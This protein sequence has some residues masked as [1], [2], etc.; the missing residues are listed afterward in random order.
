MLRLSCREGFTNIY[1]FVLRDRSDI[2]TLKMKYAY[3]QRGVINIWLSC[4]AL[5]DPGVLKWPYLGDHR[6]LKWSFFGFY[7]FGYE[8]DQNIKKILQKRSNVLLRA[9]F[10]IV[11]FQYSKVKWKFG[12]IIPKCTLN[13]EHDYDSGPFLIRV[14]AISKILASSQTLPHRTAFVFHSI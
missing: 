2:D 8:P 3:K 14:S 6:V 12:S 4:R 10:W 13:F 1:T 5:A 7:L 9:G 11:Q